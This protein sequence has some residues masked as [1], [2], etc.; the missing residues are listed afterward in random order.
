MPAGVFVTIDGPIAEVEVPDPALRRTVARRLVDAAQPEAWRVELRT[1]RRPGP[2]Y[3]AP[4]EIVDRAGLI[5]HEDQQPFDAG[6]LHIEPVLQENTT[7]APIPVLSDPEPLDQDLDP[8]PRT[9]RGSSVPAWRAFLTSRAIDW[10]LE[11][12]RADLIARWDNHNDR[13]TS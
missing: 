10:G 13:S 12:S 1:T 6:G 9:G 2:V 8:P 7:E 11:D 4:I 3:V 5:D